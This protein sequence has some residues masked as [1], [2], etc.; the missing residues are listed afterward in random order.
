MYEFGSARRAPSQLLVIITLAVLLLPAVVL[1]MAATRARNLQE[2]QMIL[3]LG[4]GCLL[5][6]FGCL[7][8]LGRRDGRLSLGTTVLIL[9]LTGIGGLWS[10]LG[11]RHPSD[12]FF[13]FAFA[14]LLLVALVV[15]GGQI[16][17]DSGAQEMRSARMLAQRLEERKNWPADLTSCRTLSEV[18]A[19]REAI[20]NDPVPALALLLQPRPE[21]RIAAL[22]ALEFR[23]HWEKGQAEL[24]LSVAQ[25]SP[26]VPVRAAAITALANID[27]RL[28]IERLAEYLRDPSI[29]IRRA[30][31]EALLWNTE[32]RWPWIRE[33]VRHALAD[34]TFQDDGQL[35]PDGQV[36]S[37]EAV[38]DLLAWASDKGVLAIRSAQ[39][40]AVHYERLLNE[41]AD[42]Q[43]VEDLQL[44]L[45]DPHASAALRMELAQLLKKYN[46][47]PKDLHEKLLDPL[48][49]A[50]LRLIA[51][52]AL[53]SDGTSIH[54]VAA[55]REVARLPNREIAL[56]TAEVV[57]RRLGLDMG[58]TLGEPLPAI[59]SRKAADVTRRVMTWAVE[60]EQEESMAGSESLPG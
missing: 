10:G 51:A 16:L 52:E 20:H 24:V 25:H 34:P 53:L 6:M 1:A 38:D 56:S 5:I 31:T 22:A 57:Q 36:L 37:Q 60:N 18:K 49:P 33:I 41:G 8:L 54:A 21:V 13:H 11:S 59:Q 15:I 23:R 27:D 29:E 17:A 39:T 4:A 50:P 2:P 30:T 3:W 45:V 35:I 55:L 46:L 32:R 43:V 19:L 12:P 9:Y 26:E 44:A 47:L 48:N 7:Q 40:L 42:E 58:L 14:I 28:M